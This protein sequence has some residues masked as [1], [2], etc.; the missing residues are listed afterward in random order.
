MAQETAEQRELLIRLVEEAYDGG[1]AVLQPLS[2]YAFEDRGIYRVDWE[3]GTSSVLRAFLADVTVELT[4]HATVLDY[5]HRHAF[6]A[7][8]V[9]KTRNGGVLASY[10]GWTALLL[11]F[12]EGE[13][14]DFA[15][16]SLEVLGSLTGSLHRLSSDVLAETESSSLPE[17]RLR[18]TLSASEAIDHLV[19]VL[20]CVP[21]ALSQ[22]CEDAMATLQ[23]VQE[24][25]Q[26]GLL[27]E[28]LLHGDCWPK[29]AVQQGSGGMALIDWD[30]A[31]IG[32]AILEVGYLLLACHLGKPQLPAMH[33]DS[34][35]IAAVVHGYCQQ[36][37]PSAVELNMLEEAVL[38]DVARRVGL[39]KR[40]STLS[41]EW[42]EDVWWQKMLARYRVGP[43][44]A[45]IARRSFEQEIQSNDF[46]SC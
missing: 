13:E 31:G 29:N 46:Q 7:P 16:E 25:Q 12:L 4:G 30:C 34:Q 8:E 42:T 14:T 20:P 28:T 27:P 10:E 45:T 21:S 17:S 18:P 36:R 15:P 41:D 26:A 9:T 39:E 23:R 11:S 40:L 3:D 33:A 37:K 32:P 6:T 35:R 44:I 1:K 22:F 2:P 24:A 43:A 5:L 38:Y 19:Q